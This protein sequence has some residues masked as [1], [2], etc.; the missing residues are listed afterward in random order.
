MT[1]DQLRFHRRTQPCCF[2]CGR[3]YGDEYGFPDL[4]V[5]D[6]VWAKIAPDEG[7]GLLCPS[8]MCRRLYLVGIRCKGRFTS[9][10]LRGDGE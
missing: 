1:H 3:R 4:I 7:N 8:C 9:G 2:D 10:P 5:P 6:D